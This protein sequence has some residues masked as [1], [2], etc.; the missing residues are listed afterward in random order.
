MAMPSKYFVENIPV[1]DIFVVG[2]RRAVDDGAVNE[3]VR[4]IFGGD[5][6]R[7]GIGLQT[8]ITVRVDDSIPDPDTGEIMGAYALV[9]GA[10]RLEAYRRQGETC[11][12]AIVRDCTLRETE[13]WEIAEN[14]HR[15]ELTKEQRD[16]YIRRYA[17]LL[18]APIEDDAQNR[19]EQTE[20]PEIGY[21][22]PPPAQKGIARKIADETGLS[23]STVHRALNPDRRLSKAAIK[24][25]MN[26]APPPKQ[27]RETKASR[28]SYE[29][30][31][32]VIG[33]L[34]DELRK[35]EIP[36]RTQQQQQ[37][38]LGSIDR[39]IK[40]LRDLRSRLARVPPGR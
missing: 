32:G 21:K 40:A 31:L 20:P 19:V 15:A 10:H 24:R 17:E 3:L 2:E 30:T 33:T 39:A 4:S 36:A 14:L 7:A 25:A 37:N 27:K 5:D 13:M 35:L 18:A 34:G 22:K 23:K 6:G 1:D 8:P 38:D 29:H 16:N 28:E 9:V 11:I 26:A 12:P